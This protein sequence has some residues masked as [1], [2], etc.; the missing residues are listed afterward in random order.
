MQAEA[1]EERSSPRTRISP[2][3]KAILFFGLFTMSFQVI[4]TLIRGIAGLYG[5][6]LLLLHTLAFP[7]V[8]TLFFM[9][10]LNDLSFHDLG[11]RGLRKAPKRFA[12]G[13]I[14]G[15]L[16]ILSSTII[17]CLLGYASVALK[18]SFPSALELLRKVLLMLILVYNEELIF[19]GYMFNSARRSGLWQAMILS[20]LTFG[21]VHANNPNAN[22]L[23]V[24]GLM[25]AGFLLSMSFLLYD[26]IWVPMGLH[27]MWNLT[28]EKIFGMPLSGLSPES[29]LFDT[30][31]V[32]PS[33]I[34]GGKFGPEGGIVLISVEFILIL[35]CSKFVPRLKDPLESLSDFDR[36]RQC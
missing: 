2:I 4:S 7:T 29:W 8:F 9:K 19:R 25:I 18:P 26:E 14:I 30:E 15:F 6:F 13:A 22:V 10:L 31:L 33:W 35:I 27:F 20:S 11:F 24:F 28:E 12:L 21:I 5:N 32:G 16:A 34:T 3:P 1:T 23:A 17:F 36:D